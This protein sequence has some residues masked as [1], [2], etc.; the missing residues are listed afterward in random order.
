MKWLGK[1]VRIED[2]ALEIEEFSSVK[3]LY[4]NYLKKINR[5]H[6]LAGLQMEK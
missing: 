3:I 4:F 2:G 1:N 5:K 6:I